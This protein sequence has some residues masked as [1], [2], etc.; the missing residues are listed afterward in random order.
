MHH[1]LGANIDTTDYFSIRASLARTG[2]RGTTEAPIPANV[3][4]YDVAGASHGRSRE[5]GCEMPR[6]ELDWSP[7]M[8][9]VLAALDEW[10]SHNRLPPPNTLMPLEA[11]PNDETIL[12]APAHLP[13]AII[14]VPRQDFRRQLHRRNPFA[15]CGSAPRRPR[16]SEPPALRPIVQSFGCLCGICQEAQRSQ[17]GRQPPFYY[18]TIQRSGGLR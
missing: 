17:A 11:R 18:R 15:R 1:H 9:A 6:G 4:I 2:S 13:N 14:Q 3:R 16:H 5:P 12:P 8:R 10:V 7:V